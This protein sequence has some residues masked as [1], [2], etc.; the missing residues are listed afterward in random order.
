[1][2]KCFYTSENSL[3]STCHLIFSDL[4][5]NACDN[6]IDRDF[7]GIQDDRDNCVSVPNADQLDTDGD[8]KGDVCDSD[9]DN[10]GIPNERDN[11]RYIPVSFLQP[12]ILRN[13]S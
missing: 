7:D 1:M 6:N 10:D 12:R 2:G 8:G 5:G 11:C 3:R 13:V 4:V 9:I